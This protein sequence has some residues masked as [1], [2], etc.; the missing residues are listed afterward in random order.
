MVAISIIED[1]YPA[2]WIFS[3]RQH[4]LPSVGPRV[5]IVNEPGNSFAAELAFRPFDFFCLMPETLL[6]GDTIFWDM[7]TS[8]WQRM[9]SIPGNRW[10]HITW[11]RCVLDRG[12]KDKGRMTFMQQT[13]RVYARSHS[14]TSSREKA[15]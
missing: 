7:L 6:P 2:Y 10:Y 5:S 1:K 3:V 13:N 12:M 9:I 4:R 11:T 8:Q 15:A 14:N